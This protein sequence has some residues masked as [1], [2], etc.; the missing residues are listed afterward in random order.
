M[1]LQMNKY[2]W[3]QSEIREK[4][5]IATEE[6]EKE[7]QKKEKEMEQREKDRKRRSGTIAKGKKGKKY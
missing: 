4:H 6:K 1:K 3:L 2:M 7:R 5:R